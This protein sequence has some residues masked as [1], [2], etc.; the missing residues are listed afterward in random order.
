MNSD[1]EHVFTCAIVG[2]GSI[3]MLYDYDDN[4][5]VLTHAKAVTE[6]KNFDLKFG[7]D[8]CE[9][10]R[11][12]F[13][14]KFQKPAYKTCEQ[15]TKNI[16]LDL[17]I[18]ATPSGSYINT[19]RKLLKALKPKSLLCEKPLGFDYKEAKEF[20]DNEVE[21]EI[22]NNAYVNYIR[23]ADPST[24]KIAN[25]INKSM[26]ISSRF[27]GNCFYTK[28]VYNNASHFLNLLCSWFGEC[29]DIQ[30]L[31]KR[32][33]LYNDIDFDADFIAS[34]QNG[35]II[36]QAGDK[37]EYTHYGLEIYMPTGRLRYDYGGEL[38]TFSGANKEGFISMKPL[39]IKSDLDY[40]QRNIYSDLYKAL[41]NQ[42]HSLSTVDD[43]LRTLKYL[44]QEID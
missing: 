29:N 37:I 31:T 35:R 26:R 32:A 9:T 4:S 21:L 23:R 41:S 28:G 34:F 30:Y 11:K 17:L 16:D 36:F 7:I 13:E 3:G 43:A 44:K 39:V 18:V 42:E 27:T 14:R 1:T 38:I 25:I 6:S 10:N 19:C 22:R 5:K 8:I 12:L 15:V 24:K 2:L 20:F 40:Y 33:T